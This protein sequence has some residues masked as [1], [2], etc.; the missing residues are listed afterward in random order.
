MAYNDSFPSST[1][2]PGKT[3]TKKKAI[4][5]KKK[6]SAAVHKKKMHSHTSIYRERHSPFDCLRHH[7]EHLVTTSTVKLETGKKYFPTKWNGMKISSLSWVAGCIIQN[8]LNL[9]RHLTNLINTLSPTNF[10]RRLLRFNELNLKLSLDSMDMGISQYFCKTKNYKKWCLAKN[11]LK[12]IL[13]YVALWIE[14]NKESIKICQSYW[15]IAK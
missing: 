2:K 15:K 3:Q 6:K 8:W 13:E 5:K 1:Y 10:L 9:L 12:F 7:Y 11:E 4:S 14:S